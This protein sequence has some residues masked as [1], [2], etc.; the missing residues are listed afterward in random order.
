MWARMQYDRWNKEVQEESKAKE[1]NRHKSEGDTKVKESEV[2][3]D[4]I[5]VKCGPTAVEIN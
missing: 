5:K 1:K 4:E 3:K 2:K